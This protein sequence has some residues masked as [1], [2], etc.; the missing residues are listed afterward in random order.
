MR[1]STLSIIVEIPRETKI[2]RNR[3]VQYVPYQSGYIFHHI[4]MHRNMYTN[5]SWNLKSTDK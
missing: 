2:M 5:D 1:L 4:Q 3:W